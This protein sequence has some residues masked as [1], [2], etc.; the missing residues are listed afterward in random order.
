MALSPRQPSEGSSLDEWQEQGCLRSSLILSDGISI[1]ESSVRREF[2]R[3]SEEGE[4][5][6]EED[7][8]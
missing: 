2:S 6:K 8:V 5:W 7:Y 1:E 4:C 3:L